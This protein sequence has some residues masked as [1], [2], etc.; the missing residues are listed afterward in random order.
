MN[1]LVEEH[2]DIVSYTETVK[3]HHFSLQNLAHD[4]FFYPLKN[5]LTIAEI[6]IP[7]FYLIYHSTP[8]TD[9]QL[10]FDN[11]KITVDTGAVLK[12]KNYLY[13]DVIWVFE[14]SFITSNELF[15]NFSFL[16]VAITIECYKFYV[17]LC[18]YLIIKTWHLSIKHYSHFFF[19]FLNYVFVIYL[20]KY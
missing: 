17:T 2:T 1:Y 18:L 7:N 12:M 14:S 5:F 6:W 11:V 3:L 8:I 20:M 4:D 19:F 15:S 9:L 13:D 10:Q 16:I